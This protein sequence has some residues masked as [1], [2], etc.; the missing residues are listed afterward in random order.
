MDRKYKKYYGLAIFVAA[1]IIA[2]VLAFVLVIRP[3]GESNRKAETEIKNL[4][5]KL[6]GLQQKEKQIDAKLAEI[7]ESASS[8]QK[9]IYSPIEADL[10]NDTLFFTMYNDVIE[11]LHANS[12]KIKSISYKYNPENDPFVSAGAD[13]Y[14]VCDV[15]ME[16]VS[17]YVNLGKFIQDVYKY[18]YYIRINK[19]NVKPYIRDKKILITDLGLRLYAHTTPQDTSI[20][21]DEGETLK[22]AKTTLPQ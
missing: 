18:P 22:N 21:E 3:L 2:L 9:K 1:I 19:V 11:M 12:V 5:N 8:G 10:G 6:S 7:E 20:L 17:N 14:F 15:S 4:Q 16:V 13:K